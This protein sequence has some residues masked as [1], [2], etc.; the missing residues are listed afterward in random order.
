MSLAS[1]FSEEY[2]GVGYYSPESP[3]APGL[4]PGGR[5]D[6]RPPRWTN[7]R[8][9]EG[10]ECM[11]GRKMLYSRT[12]S[13]PS[14]IGSRQGSQFSQPIPATSSRATAVQNVEI[15]KIVETVGQSCM[16][17]YGSLHKALRDIRTDP[18]GNLRR[19]DLRRW[20]EEHHVAT[21]MADR[22]FDHI[23]ADRG[24]STVSMN[25]MKNVFDTVVG[26]HL[27]KK[28]TK[29]SHHH[30]HNVHGLLR[31]Q[32]SEGSIISVPGA[33]TC[34]TAMTKDR[35]KKIA[36][37]MTG[38]T[39]RRYIDKYGNIQ[40]QELQHVF[41]SYGLAPEQANELFDTI[42]NKREGEIK[43]K[44]LSKHLAQFLHVEEPKKKV[45]APAS[46]ERRLDDYA[47]TR[48][49]DHIG[50]KASQKHRT[51]QGAMRA[52]DRDADNKIDR[53]EVRNFFRNYGSKTKLADRFFEAI[54][55]NREGKIDFG[56]FQ[57]K[58]SPFIQPGYHPPKPGEDQKQFYKDAKWGQSLYEREALQG[59]PQRPQ[60][61][62]SSR[63][64][65]ASICHDEVHQMRYGRFEGVS[66]YQSS[67]NADIYQQVQSPSP[68][69]QAFGW[70][71][72]GSE[73][74][75]FEGISTYQAM[76]S[77]VAAQF[78]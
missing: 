6:E 50:G 20:F 27:G 45:A 31:P 35:L 53:F 21:R 59:R 18:E 48:I 40:R 17:Q 78:S 15:K 23:T 71:Q 2:Q 32:H 62:R 75:R 8:S 66:T 30:H 44:E 13:E 9:R 42:D 29:A 47:M 22:F 33:D 69:G 16:D 51:V 3:I 61:S 63:S 73:P 72:N 43:F 1:G 38:K 70:G 24:G 57:D 76:N 64:N 26:D 34:P 74:P 10:S 60:S 54:D 77:G 56:E 55:V 12:P 68:S 7:M 58:F 5:G 52:I 41:E 28:D 46:R 4:L 14:V 25:T 49:C 19:P 36:K 37:Q 65:S 67:F 11:E 39:Q